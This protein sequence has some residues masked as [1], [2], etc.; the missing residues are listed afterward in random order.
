MP[1]RFAR[2]ARS[3]SLLPLAV[4]ALAACPRDKKDGEQVAVDTMLT[5]A[6]TPDTALPPADLSQLTSNIPAAAPDTFRRKSGAD[7]AKAEGLSTG[8]STSRI[9]DAPALLMETVQ[10][11]VS[12]QRFCYQEFG[13]KA[14]PTLAGNVAMIVTVGSSGISGAEVGNSRWT[15]STGRAVN[16]CLSQKAKQAWKL[17]PGAVKPGRYVVQ[18][19][20]R[21]T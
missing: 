1:V 6:M 4:L 14:D 12:F 19:S 11:E 13:Q 20:F 2:V 18:L 8:G 3:A 17:E 5:R 9:P 7:I 21:G 16:T 15:S 10:R